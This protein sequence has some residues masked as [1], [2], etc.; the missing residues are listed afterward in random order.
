MS[1]FAN[2]KHLAS[3]T[4]NVNY[5]LW[6]GNFFSYFILYSITYNHIVIIYDKLYIIH[7][8]LSLIFLYYL[9]CLLCFYY[10]TIFIKNINKLTTIWKV[11][12]SKSQLFLFQL[13]EDNR[14]GC[15]WTEQEVAENSGPASSPTRLS[16][17]HHSDL[18]LPAPPLCPWCSG[19]PGHL[20][21]L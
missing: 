19:L 20:A 15:L 1:I 16:P 11:I 2:K 21:V 17:A 5:P 3:C 14:R 13:P 8:K 4:S 18:P 7:F 9:I 12:K 10:I 6:M